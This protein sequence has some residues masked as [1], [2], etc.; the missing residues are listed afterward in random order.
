MS[1]ATALTGFQAIGNR[2]DLTD[3]VTNIS[4]AETPML[5]RFGRSKARGTYHEWQ[6]DTLASAT[7]NAA[8]EGGDY[9]FTRVGVR[10]RAGNWTQI[11]VTDVEVSD[12]QRAVDVAG[13]SDEFA[14]Q[15]T[16]GM[17][18][19]ARDIEYAFV[20]GTGN[21]GASGTARTLKGVLSFMTTNVETGTGTSTSETLTADMLNDALQTIWTSG[22]RPNEV[23]VNG[24]QKR[25]ISG[26]TSSN[27][28]NIGASEKEVV[29]GVDVYD[30]DFGRLKIILDRYMTTSVIAILQSDLWRTAVLRPTKRVDVAK[31]GSATRA[32][33]ETE[34]T[35]ESLNE[36]GSGQITGLATS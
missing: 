20:N 16:K 31:V 28:R 19:H 5:S 2:E 24:F 13:V 12:T 14:Y 17:K 27:T 9:S 29:M 1:N 11:F 30:S 10:T 33:V 32:V 6:T 8:I 15:M 21:S 22:G 35:L 25:A 4:P 34:L 23:Y 3:V 7:A 36:A 18:E 26:L